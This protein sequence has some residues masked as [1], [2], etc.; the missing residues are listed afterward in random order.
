M[1][2]F[3]TILFMVIIGAFIGGL[4]NSLAI[5]M[6]F[7]P[8]EPKFIGKFKIPFTPGLIPKR[9]DQLA[10]QM[11][12]LVVQHLLTEDSIR[13]KLQGEE[14]KQIVKDKLTRE[15]TSLQTDDRSLNEWLHKL[16]IE[17][18]KNEVQQF[19]TQ[20]GLQQMDQA[21]VSW[22]T[23]TVDEALG[24]FVADEELHQITALLQTKI[25][26]IIASENT[27]YQL[28]KVINSYVESKG[29]FGNMI[30]SM[31]NRED[32]SMKIQR[33]LISYF[34]SDDGYQLI[35]KNITKE[36]KQLKEQELSKWLRVMYKDEVRKTIESTLSQVLSVDKLL[37]LP[38]KSLLSPVHSKVKNDWI[39]LF[40]DKA[41]DVL[42]RQI[43][44][45]LQQLNLEKMVETQVS[46]FPTKRMEEMVLS[47]SKKE[48]KWITYLG[49]L[50]GGWIGLLQGLILLF[51]S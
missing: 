26:G 37:Q 43:P 39:P 34:Q 27:R 33:L 8:Y 17:I 6:L 44:Q 50:L 5:K 30:L 19:I 7:R 24:K 4:T 29:F 40:T 10:Q 20:K 14:L 15:W 45:I 11:G 25:H 46:T 12:E 48:F 18:D 36:W 21:V 38:V 22:S 1:E 35:Y 32:L 49:A 23:K 13:N 9:R 28:E 51:T 16:G 42:V 3:L 47:I 41:F 2:Q 31:F